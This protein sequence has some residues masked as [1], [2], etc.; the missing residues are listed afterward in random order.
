MNPRILVPWLRTL[1]TLTP[2]FV[3][4]LLFCGSNTHLTLF[5]SLIHKHVWFVN[6]IFESITFFMFS[7]QQ[8]FTFVCSVKEF[9]CKMWLIT[10][11]GVGRAMTRTL[12]LQV[13]LNTSHIDIYNIK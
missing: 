6:I 3:V 2:L 9:S 12:D 8:S 4:Q 11:I 13:N 5:I 10:V 1:A 7:L